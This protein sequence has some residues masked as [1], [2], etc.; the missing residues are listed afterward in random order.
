MAAIHIG[1]AATSLVQRQEEETSF[2]L[3]DPTFELSNTASDFEQ[4]TA[5]SLD[6]RRGQ[7]AQRLSGREAKLVVPPIPEETLD[8]AAPR[9]PRRSMEAVGQGAPPTFFTCCSGAVKG[10][11]DFVPGHVQCNV[12]HGTIAGGG[13]QSAGDQHGEEVVLKPVIFR[14]GHALPPA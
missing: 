9:L 13:D 7:P 14:G 2:A 6:D 12:T 5:G 4:E 1:Q 10:R 8:S 3:T 11:C